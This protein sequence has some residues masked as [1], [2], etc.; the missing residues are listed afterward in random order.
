MRNF[1]YLKIK[2]EKWDSEVLSLVAAIYRYQGRQE[3]YL[4]QKPAELN[5]LID[6]AKIQS[7]EASNEIEGII[8]TSTRLQKLVEEKTTP[9]NRNEQEIVGYWD[10]LNIIHDSFDV[11]PVS[12]KLYSSDA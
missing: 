1:D 4:K 2:E 12:K 11:I 8:T 9:R 5:K 7:T 3:F 6:I 10:V